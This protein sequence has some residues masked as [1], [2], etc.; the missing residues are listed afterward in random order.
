MEGEKGV[1]LDGVELVKKALQEASSDL[2]FAV[3]KLMSEL[4]VAG[5]GSS[6]GGGVITFAP[7]NA[8]HRKL[9]HIMVRVHLTHT[10]SHRPSPLPLS[11]HRSGE[12]N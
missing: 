9:V 8:Y 11:S 5:G 12:M 10:P 4:V 7:L 1:K 2:L 3:D 6:S